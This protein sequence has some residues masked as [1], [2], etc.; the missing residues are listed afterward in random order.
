MSKIVLRDC[1]I[2]S[3]TFS[4]DTVPCFQMFDWL[5]VWWKTFF[6]TILYI[7]QE[8]ILASIFVVMIDPIFRKIHGLEQFQFCLWK[9]VLLCSHHSFIFIWVSQKQQFTL[10]LRGPGIEGFCAVQFYFM[11][12][13]CKI[14]A[15]VALCRHLVCSGSSMNKL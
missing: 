13:F 2:T 5:W 1:N 8:P 10:Q 9:L 6:K 14:Y 3:V 15:L 11:R 7:Q 4:I 12:F